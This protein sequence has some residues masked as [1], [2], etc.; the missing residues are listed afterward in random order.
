MHI[1]FSFFWPVILGL[2]EPN[3]PEIWQLAVPDIDQALTRFKAISIDSIELKLTESLDQRLLFRAIEKLIQQGFHVTFHAPGRFQ[4]PENLPQQLENLF[5]ISQFVNQEF[6]LTPLWVVHPLNSKTQQ[7]SEAYAETI[8]YIQRVLTAMTAIP[9]R[10]ALEILRNRAD[11]GKLHIGDSYQEILDILSN[12]END[13]LG[14]CWDFGHANAMYQRGLQD[15]FP[16]SEFL[17]KVIHCH[18]HDC[19][20]QKTHL[21]LGMGTVPIE[22]NMQLLLQHDYDGILNLELVPH[23]IDQPIHFIKHI[24][25]SVQTIQKCIGQTRKGF[26]EVSKQSGLLTGD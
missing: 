23:R 13:D 22:Q 12:F 10:F 19:W 3:K 11:G 6:Q 9:A 18:V 8:H 5:T 21:P 2:P 17:K 25:Q 16:P 4:Y 20:D 7:R 15:Q 1:G 24:A 26:E 14:I